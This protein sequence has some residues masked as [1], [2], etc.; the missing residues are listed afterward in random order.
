MNKL[1]TGIIIGL[2]VGGMIGYFSHDLISE[3]T[4][5]MNA[6]EFGIGDETK[7]EVISFFDLNPSNE[8]VEIYCQENRKN[9]VYYCREINQE[10]EICSEIKLQ[11]EI[12]KK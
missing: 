3:S 12:L 4:P 5:K 1:I 10:H 7:S 11:K 6:G 2:I 9:C 8:E